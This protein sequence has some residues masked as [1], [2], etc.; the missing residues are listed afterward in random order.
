VSAINPEDASSSPADDPSTDLRGSPEADSEQALRRRAEALASERP[1]EVPENLEALSPDA[2][3]R[4]LHELR[5]HQIELEMQNVEL[6]R[7]QEELE[8]SR[9][10]YFDLYDLAPV[11]Y[12]TLSERGLI[13]EANLTAAKLLGVARGPLI[14]QPLSRFILPED[15]DIHYRHFKPL[16]ETGTPQSWELRLLR[17]NTAPFWARL[18]ATTSQD[19]DAAS[20]CRAV[21]SDITERKRAEDVLR[22]SEEKYRQL[23]ESMSEGFLLVEAVLGE[24][25]KPV[26]YRYLDANP[27]LENLTRLK[28]QEIIGKDVREVLPRIE[29]HWIDTFGQ[30]ALTGVPMRIEALCKDLNGWYEVYAYSRERGKAAVIYT[31]VTE[32]RVVREALRASEER[33]TAQLEASNEELDAFSYSVSHDLRA[34]LRAVDGFSRILLEKYRP[35]LPAEAQKY[36][37]LAR[38]SALHMGELID[39]LLALSHLGRQELKRKPVAV[40]EIVRRSMDDLRADCEGRAVEFV[41]GAL[42][43]CEADRLLLRQVFANLLSNALKYTRKREKARIEVGAL[44]FGQVSRQGE[45][46][47]AGRVLPPMPDPECW[48]YYV[49]DNGAGFDMRHANKLFGVFQRLHSVKDFAGTGV[50]LAT[51]QRIIHKHGGQVWA[52]AAVDKGATFY[53]TIGAPVVETTRSPTAPGA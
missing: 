24:S 16:L 27:A 41:I 19:A 32:R 43:A 35:Q 20:V 25:G 47:K 1:G 46:D 7:T 50:G 40:A 22:K 48:V 31:N 34:P 17:K 52:E 2:V 15:Q 30:V 4:A 3:R 49:R 44:K 53:F 21:V 38:Q 33:R 9:A 12:F 28:R 45:S 8:G 18:E 29:P 14:K 23:F 51:V 36:L 37:D 11:G 42:P 39:G 26:S 13:L 5:V 10:R 6:R